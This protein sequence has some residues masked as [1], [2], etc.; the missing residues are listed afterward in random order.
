MAGVVVAV[1]L[2]APT[3]AA[4][5]TAESG[6]HDRPGSLEV[7][8]F[9]EE[10]IGR[11]GLAGVSVAVVRH[12]EI[13]HAEGY[14]HG[15]TGAEVTA[16]TPMPLASVSKSVTAMAVLR[17]AED[18]GIE[19]DTPV[20][21]YMDGFDPVD[22]RAEEITPRQLL[23]QTSGIT[24]HGLLSPDRQE[25]TT[26]EQAADVLSGMEL[27]SDPGTGH[28]YQN[29]N[30]W[31]LAG[32]VESVSGEPF[33]SYLDREVFRPLGMEDSTSVDTAD[34][35]AGVDESA[36]GHVDVYGFP[37]PR[38]EQP[39]FVAGSGNTVSTA[40]DMARWLVPHTN[41]GRSVTGEPFVGVDTLTEALTPSDPAG[42]YG[43]GWRHVPGEGRVA[44]GGALFGHLSYQTVTDGGLGVAVLS[45]TLT[46][47]YD[48]AQ[49]L[50]V[51]LVD[52]F[53]G[54]SPESPL[55]YHRIIDVVLTGLTLLSTALG[56]RR[57]RLAGVWAERH[58]DRPAWK[59]TLRSAARLLPALLVCGFA[60]V[61]VANIAVVGASP[62]T[63][64]AIAAG[65]FWPP[66]F[67]VWVVVAA[68][69]G[70]ATVVLRA[71]R[72]RSAR[73]QEPPPQG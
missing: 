49:P 69:F 63:V 45:N 6:T 20:R 72:L 64:A 27:G 18:G 2:T 70:L 21:E 36:P 12:G 68:A 9:V 3:A 7:D 53:E 22:P 32:L 73:S 48:T 13:L 55:P 44:H 5:A 14:G 16:H 10:H 26:T 59:L 24:S 8:R 30:Y 47:S 29:G 56:V 42:R 40:G 37:V 31:L 58:S 1:L 51:G 61:A 35:F 39:D 43:Y 23:D 50:A 62:R 15:S 38:E 4:A 33:G 34:A 71:H 19:L 52:L 41:G 17:L 65:A 25:I 28:E 11:H 60:A 54:R 57:L 67:T 46:T 66:S